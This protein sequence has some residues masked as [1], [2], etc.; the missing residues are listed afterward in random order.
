MNRR[1][2]I[3]AALGAIAAG[4]YP[5]DKT[6]CLQNNATYSPLS[7]ADVMRKF[8]AAFHASFWHEMAHF[9]VALGVTGSPLYDRAL[10]YL[11]SF[12]EE[13]RGAGWEH[14]AED[15]ERLCLYIKNKS[16]TDDQ[17]CI[18]VSEMFKKA[19]RE[20]LR[21]RY[22]QLRDS[23]LWFYY[24]ENPF[25]LLVSERLPGACGDVDEA[26]K[27]FAL[28]RYTASAFH[29]IRAAEVGL[30]VILTTTENPKLLSKINPSFPWMTRELDK[31]ANLEF[32][33]W[34]PQWKLNRSFYDA[35]VSKYRSVRIAE[36][37]PVTHPGN[38][39]SQESA[40]HLWVS[41]KDLLQFIA[42]NLP[43]GQASDQ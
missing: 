30:R 12:A 9:M 17:L 13:A 26:C 8:S 36:R 11:E 32:E 18:L 6:D 38:S 29:S 33:L 28:G 4:D 24:E 40:H 16:H 21:S 20:M 22:F 41:V 14:L 35:V 31:I 7:V 25:G 3:T 2:F 42:E 37:N 19:Q 10:E 5:F 39:Y 27:C 34:P 43:E 15:A 1:S 23:D